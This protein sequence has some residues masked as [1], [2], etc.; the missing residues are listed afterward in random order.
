MYKTS[1]LVPTAKS[2]PWGYPYP[3]SLSLVSYRLSIAQ[4]CVIIAHGSNTTPCPQYQTQE[5]FYTTI[6]GLVICVQSLCNVKCISLFPLQRS[7]IRKACTSALPFR[8]HLI[9]PPFYGSP[10]KQKLIGKSLNFGTQKQP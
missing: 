5:E 4:S 7:A 10:L 3:T 9:A 8:L 2:Q 6:L 1:N